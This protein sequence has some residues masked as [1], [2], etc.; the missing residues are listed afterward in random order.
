MGALKDQLIE[1]VTEE[2]KDRRSCV[3]CAHYEEPEVKDSIVHSGCTKH[4]L[5]KFDPITGVSGVILSNCLDLNKNG[6]CADHSSID[7]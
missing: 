6:Q 7:G 2:H 5:K 3:T 4:Y 1:K